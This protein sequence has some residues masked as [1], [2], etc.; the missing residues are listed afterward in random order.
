MDKH[1]FC[2]LTHQ[3]CNFTAFEYTGS[4]FWLS[5]FVVSAS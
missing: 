4:N 1:I 5:Y 3:K 2:E